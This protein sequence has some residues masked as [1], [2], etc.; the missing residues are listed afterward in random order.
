LIQ[1]P[2]PWKRPTRRQPDELRRRRR[3]RSGGSPSRKRRCTKSAAETS[4]ARRWKRRRSATSWSHRDDNAVESVP[5]NNEDDA[6]RGRPTAVALR[7]TDDRQLGDAPSSECSS[8]RNAGWHPPNHHKSGRVSRRKLAFQT[9]DEKRCF[10]EF[11]T[12][13]LS[14]LSTSENSAQTTENHDQSVEFS[15]SVLFNTE[16]LVDHYIKAREAVMHIE[17]SP[18]T[19]YDSRFTQTDTQGPT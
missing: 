4:A 1:L 12:L 5:T 3:L 19:A 17:I 11:C 13:P 18:S 14:P 9:V 15:G 7:L 8:L 2:S 10:A 16:Q 6:L